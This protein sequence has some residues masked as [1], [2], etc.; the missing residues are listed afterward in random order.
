MAR[1]L[2]TGSNQDVGRALGLEGGMLCQLI[3][4]PDYNLFPN[5]AVFESN[6]IQVTKKGKWMDITHT[7]TI[8]TLAVTSS[9]PCLPLPNVLL[10]ANQ[11]APLQGVHPGSPRMSQMDL[12]R[13][14]PLRYV[15]LSVHSASQRILRLQTVTKTVYYLQLHHKHPE[16][17]F[18]LWNRLT[19]ILENGLSTTTKD[20]AIPIRHCLVS[21]RSSST[22]SISPL[23]EH[24][25]MVMTSA[26][27]IK[28]VGR[29]VS[30]ITTQF[31]PSPKQNLEKAR[32]VSFQAQQQSLEDTSGLSSDIKVLYYDLPPPLV[33]ARC[34]GRLPR[35]EPRKCRLDARRADSE[36]ELAP[37]MDRRTHGLWQQET[38]T[39]LQPPCRLSCLAAAGWK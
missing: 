17:V 35:T 12:T 38:P 39:W 28:K 24:S 19:N 5:S 21:S 32:R 22:S 4:S 33:C 6:F 3:R 14:L 31:S 8:V 20:P 36:V 15:R 7:P 29:K 2:F 9:D 1:G 34:K 25:D 30:G 26:G 10:M 23:V 37:W 27:V 13:L 11:R 18:A 16:A